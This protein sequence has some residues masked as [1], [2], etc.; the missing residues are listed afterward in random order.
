MEPLAPDDE[1]GLAAAGAV[2]AAG[3]AGFAA[4]VGLAAA[5]AG[6]V[7]AAA[8]AGLVA[9]AGLAGAEVAAGAGA[10][11]A[12]AASRP[13]APTVMMPQA[14]SSRLVNRRAAGARVARLVFFR[15]IVGRHSIVDLPVPSLHGERDRRLASMIFRQGSVSPPVAYRLIFG[16]THHDVNRSSSGRRQE[17]LHAP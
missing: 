11:G 5:A 6:A 12:H 7:V 17:R 1:D 10:C 9:S 14:M 15:R 8:A 2:V 16:Q 4:S 3:A 13:A